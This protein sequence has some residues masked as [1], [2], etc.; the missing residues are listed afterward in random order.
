MAGVGFVIDKATKKRIH[1]DESDGRDADNKATNFL[2]SYA[3]IFLV[4][5]TKKELLILQTTFYYRFHPCE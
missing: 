1:R 4:L 5:A 2:V 3:F